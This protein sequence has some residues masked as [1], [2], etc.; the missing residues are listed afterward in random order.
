M[1]TT[2]NGISIEVRLMHMAPEKFCEIYNH[3]FGAR[4]IS[5]VT[6]ATV[7]RDDTTVTDWA[8]CSASDQFSKR[9]GGTLA[10]ARVFDNPDIKFSKEE[11]T[12]IYYDL[13][14][15]NDSPY[16]LLNSYVRGRPE[17]AKHLINVS[18]RILLGLETIP[19][20][21]NVE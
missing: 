1:R 13:Y 2:I 4:K 5:K 3:D 18:K 20:E 17:L 19:P 7:T 6:V 8:A 12:Q 21:E 15:H 10:L 9:K 11:R 14:R 16:E